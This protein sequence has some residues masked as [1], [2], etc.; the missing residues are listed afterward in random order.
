MDKK[1]KDNKTTL[2]LFGATGDLV[3]RKVLPSLFELEMD[4][5]M[6]AED[7]ILFTRRDLKTEEFLRDFVRPSL[8][9]V[10][11][12]VDEK[13]YERF[14]DRFRYVRGDY[15]N[16]ED[17]KHLKESLGEKGKSNLLFYMPVYPDHLGVIIDNMKEAGVVPLDHAA[18]A[19]KRVVVE[20]PFG[21][22]LASARSIF[23]S[24]G[25]VFSTEEIYNIDHYLAKPLLR[26]M[27]SLR[28]KDEKIDNMFGSGEVARINIRLFEAAGVESRGSFYDAVG[29]FIDVGQNHVLQMLTAALVL[30]EDLD[31]DK[32]IGEAREQAL[33]SIGILTPEEIKTRTRRGQ[34]EGYRQIKEVS[35][36]SDTETY[37][38]V[39]TDIR[40]GALKGAQINLEGGKRIG[41]ENLKEIEVIFTKDPEAGREDKNERII[42]RLEPTEEIE[43][44]KRPGEDEEDVK[45]ITIQLRER[46]ERKQYTEEYKTLF[47]AAAEGNR[48]LFLAPRETLLLWEFAEA[49]IK[50]WRE[51]LRPL[52]SYPQNEH[53]AFRG[54]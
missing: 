54:K 36:N 41:K 11:D 20:K 12:S 16:N 23:D 9:R 2:V 34:Y 39:E 13:V 42:F 4:E 53:P 21:K 5:E 52:E 43:I 50:G 24:L 31:K 30:A 15:D 17:F 38:C 46:T 44:F 45:S 40:K 28:Q 8:E 6:I 48:S 18:N 26:D 51:N 25:K 7:I 22:D 1:H 37:F 32:E 33:S 47:Q 14:A 10:F 19:W 3:F 29:A 49:V 35:D 27:S